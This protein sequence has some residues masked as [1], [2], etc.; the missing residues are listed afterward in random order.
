MPI[1]FHS[2]I[3]TQLSKWLSC[4]C[5]LFTSYTACQKLSFPTVIA[6]SPALCGRNCSSWLVHS[7]VWGQPTILSRTARLSASISVWRP[8]YA[9]SSMPVRTSGTCGC[10]LQNSGT[11][12]PFT[13][14]LVALHL[15]SSTVDLHDI[16]TR[17]RHGK[18]WTPF[19]N[20]FPDPLLGGKQHR[21]REGMSATLHR[22]VTT[23]P[24]T[25]VRCCRRAW[26]AVKRPNVRYSGPEWTV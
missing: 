12:R 26:W 14:L 19:A 9:V 7:C 16:L 20:S 2:C 21:K 25:L 1:L 8:I 3:P 11:T 10:L 13:R 15:K 5:H 17:W 24:P 23:Q 4:L 18:T 22:W 6:F